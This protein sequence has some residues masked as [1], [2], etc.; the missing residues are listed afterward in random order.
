M[1]KVEL[2]FF[3]LSRVSE[4]LTQ[5][6]LWAQ[7]V[8]PSHTRQVI[9]RFN[10]TRS[11]TKGIHCHRMSNSKLI[12]REIHIVARYTKQLPSC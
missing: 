4:I 1:T 8:P 10:G 5:L 9:T 11:N 12:L 2:P 7:T 3:F 6:I